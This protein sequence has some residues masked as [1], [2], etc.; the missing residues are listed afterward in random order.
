MKRVF[1]NVTV[2]A[3]FMLCIVSSAFSSP[4][5][6]TLPDYSMALLTP[7]SQASTRWT[8]IIPNALASYF[9]YVP[10]SNA[11]AVKLGFPSTCGNLSLSNAANQASTE[12]C[13]TITVK[14]FQQQLALPGIF[15]GGAGLL[16]ASSSSFG[17]VTWV[18]GYGSGGQNWTPPGASTA[19]TGNAPAPFADGTFSTTGVWHFPAPTVRGTKGRPIRV[20]W[21]NELPNEAPAGFDP[22]VD[23]GPNAPDCFPYNRMVTHVHGAHVMDDSD[24]FAGAW[25]TPNFAL[26]GPGWAASTYGPEGTYRYPMD[27]EAGTIWYHD[28]AMGVT[29]NN[30]Q[31]GMAGFFPITDANEISL[32]TNSILPAGS[33]ELGFALQDRMFDTT[34]QF[35]MPDYPIYDRNS[36]GCTL[37]PDDLPD[38]ATCT[39]LDW[40]K[41]PADGH[42]V[43]YVPGHAFLSNPINAGAP[44]PAASTTLE[45]F[46]NMPVVNGVTYGR[47]NVEPRIYRMRFIGGTDSRTWIMKLVRRD[48]DSIIPFWQIGSEQGFLNNPVYRTTIDLMPGERIDVLVDL[49]GIPAGTKIAM[50]NIGPDSPYAGPESLLD[51]SYE[52]SLVIPEIMEFNV[53]ALTGSDTIKTP[54]PFTNL[55]PVSGMITPLVPTPGTPIRN[56]S[57]VEITDGLG[58][59]M[60]TIDIRGFM[61]D[62]VPATEIVRLNDTEEWDIINTTVDAHPM[63]LHLVAFQVISRQAFTAFVPAGTDIPNQ[64]FTQPSYV[65]SGPVLAP[66]PW[67]LGW[68][69]T[70]DVPPGMVTRIKAKFDIAGDKYVY[71]CHILSH[72]EHDMMRP[73]VVAAPVEATFAAGSNG[74]IIGTASQSV[75]YSAATGTVTAVPNTGYHFVNWTEGST[76]VSTN[77]A[78]SIS[79]VTAPHSY[80][81]HFSTDSFSVQFAAGGNGTVSGTTSQTVSYLGSAGTVTAV[82]AAGYYLVNWT[83]TGGFATTTS[84]PL[85]VSNVTASLTITAHFAALVT[86]ALPVPGEYAFTPL[87]VT[88]VANQPATI[89]FTIDGSSPTTSSAVYSV[90]IPVSATSTIRYFAVD[91]SGNIEAVRSGIWTIH[92][93]DLAAS[94]QINAGAARTN[95]PAVSLAISAFDA[96]G[97]ATMQFSNDGVSYTAEEPYATGKSWTLAGD[98]GVKTVY[99]RFRDNTP[100]SGFLY[101]PVSASIILDTAPPASSAGPAPGT[102]A[103]APIQVNL[104]ADE[105]STIYYT[106]NGTTPTAASSAYTGPITVSADTNIQYFAVDVAG[107]TEAAVRSAT[108]RIHTTDLVASI[109]INNGA[110]ATQHTAVTLALSA[111]DPA[112]ISTMQFSNDGISYTVEEP[113]ATSK[114]WTVSAGD[115][116]KTVY[117]RFRDSSLPSGVLYDP[118]SARITLDTAAPITTASPVAGTYITAPVLVTLNVN[119]TSIVYYTVNGTTPTTASSVYSA[120]LSITVDTTVNYFAVDTAGNAEAVKSGAWLIHAADLVASVKINNGAALIS[121]PTVTLTLSATDPSGIA[122]MQFSSDGVN[123]TAEEPYSASKVWRFASG[124]GVKTIYIRFRDSALPTGNLYDPVTASTVLDTIAPIV[125]AS[126]APGTNSLPI[127]VTLTADQAAVIYFT[128]DGTAPTTASTQYTGQIPLSAT[129]TIRYFAIDSAGNTGTVQSGTWTYYALPDGNLDNRI[130]VDDALRALLIA[131]GIVQPTAADL[132][133]GD[134]APL[135]GGH[136]APDGK[137]DI[138]DVVVI[139]RRAVGLVSW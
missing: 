66:Y 94:M 107:N 46:G 125:T 29:H 23:C 34:G 20:Q 128:T 100:P 127:S 111:S 76:V 30:T 18:H 60:P 79:N 6:M 31:M 39:R 118:V 85:T 14:K 99:V 21:L 43:P 26:T 126:P 129:T 109:S 25:F 69:D 24:G 110:S 52:P 12:D 78:L 112:G 62:G 115:G 98:D 17:A 77:A 65:S 86:A 88:L 19:V 102:Y 104:Y 93:G 80:V 132:L 44:F 84:N 106:T 7:D 81:A 33:Y 59:T 83:G 40:M 38:P 105:P 114:A 32:I 130:T 10:Y 87:S 72:E 4:S 8:N 117:V 113:Y 137:I 103:T 90:P 73:L 122:T 96:A 123:Y 74:S 48:T 75:A 124:D 61:E 101:A 97:I 49:T 55:R 9:T 119:E 120:P 82:P 131:S 95:N 92:T 64:I 116:D 57:L 28:H 5:A 134:V 58:R 71:H 16:N 50:K 136:P 36:P 15:G 56:V 42:L 133:V 121:S 54:S 108:W 2:M 41:N 138:G 47:Y 63:H 68:K 91:A 53:I 70:I 1:Q 35:A 37:T 135:V 67:E 11:D 22:T 139:L 89:Y 3:F 27:Q 13:Y 45:Y 51:P